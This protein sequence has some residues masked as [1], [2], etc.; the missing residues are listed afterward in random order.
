MSATFTKLVEI[1]SDVPIISDREPKENKE[2]PLALTIRILP[3]KIQILT[4]IPS[5]VAREFGKTKEDYDVFQLHDFLVALKMKNKTETTAILEPIANIDYE[6]LVKIMD[7]VR[8]LITTDPAL[9][10]KDKDN[11]DVRDDALFD[12]IIFG[13]IQS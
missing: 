2:K 5:M 12:N 13:N 9:Y 4:G 8:M 3:E 1:T 11:I 7:S 10:K 6:Q